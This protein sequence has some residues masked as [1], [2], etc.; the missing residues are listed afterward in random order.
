MMNINYNNDFVNINPIIVNNQYRCNAICNNNLASDS[1]VSIYQKQKII[2]NTVRIPASLYTNTISP[3]NTYQIPNEYIGVNWNQMSDRNQ[4]HIQQTVVPTTK[5]TRRSYTWLRP[6]S[7]SPGGK[8]VDI[9]FN[10]YDRYMN[11]IKGK[12]IGSR[13]LVLPVLYK[14]FN[15]AF[16]VYGGKTYK[17]SIVTNPSCNTCNNIE[18]NNFINDSSYKENQY[19]ESIYEQ[20]YNGESSLVN[21]N[22]NIINQGQYIEKLEQ[23]SQCVNNPIS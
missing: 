20:I 21:A 13:G 8:G 18:N 2:Q 9:K 4:R 3:L 17:T 15:P 22:N 5:S 10:S 16:P 7:L 19:M 1:P 23:E 14:Q 12:V 11:R 6:G